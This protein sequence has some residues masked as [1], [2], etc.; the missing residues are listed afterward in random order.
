ME[1]DDDMLGVGMVNCVGPWRSL[2]RA[3]PVLL[4][5]KERQM[6]GNREE[7][8]QYTIGPNLLSKFQSNS[9]LELL[10]PKH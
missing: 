9:E 7:E 6:A 10:F 4:L 8:I 1:C 3:G 2:P 5:G